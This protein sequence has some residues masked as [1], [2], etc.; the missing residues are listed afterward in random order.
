ML[1]G[2]MHVASLTFATEASPTLSQLE[3]V[4]IKN[5]PDLARLHLLAE[6]YGAIAEGASYLPDPQIRGGLANFPVQGGGFTSEPMTQFIVGVR[7]QIPQKGMRIALEA[8]ARA[9]EEMTLIEVQLRE[10]ILVRDLRHAWLDWIF[11]TRA[12]NL[13]RSNR[14]FFEDLVGITRHLYSVGSHQQ[15]DVIR[16]ELE[17]S[18]LDDQ[19]LQ[20]EQRVVDAKTRVEELLGDNLEDNEGTRLPDWQFTLDEAQLQS[21]LISHPSVRMVDAQKESDEQ[22]INQVKSTYNA[23]WSIDVSYGKRDGT[24]LNGSSRPDF[25]SAMVTMSR[26]LFGRSKQ[27]SALKAAIAMKSAREQKK[28]QQLTK[29]KA[30]LDNAISDWQS[31]VSRLQTYQD[32][33]VPQSNN[34]AQASLQAYRSESGT[35]TEVVQ[36]FVLQIDTVI[37]YEKLHVQRLAAWAQLDYLTGH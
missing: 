17:V 6:R 18:R 23:V 30:E 14:S 24:G 37:A 12:L 31:L 16:A 25:A 2:C 32:S 15:Q 22:V 33:I 4:A 9:L 34:L 3:Q 10:S 27:D 7:Q 13:V 28:Q 29:L 1:L 19:I 5:D 11:E 20:R 21:Q 8:E 26:P 36:G 35:F